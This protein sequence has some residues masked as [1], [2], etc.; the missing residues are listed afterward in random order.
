MFCEYKDIFGKPG[1]GIHSFRIFDIS[2]F[3]V[4]VVI[5]LAYIVQSF[6]P[7]VSFIFILIVLFIIG[8][9]VHR[10]FCVHTTI[11]KLLFNDSNV[12]LDSNYAPYYL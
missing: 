12:Y 8:I 2:V 3:D 1:E 5:F 9:I 7:S 6:V 10:L 11:D 4:L